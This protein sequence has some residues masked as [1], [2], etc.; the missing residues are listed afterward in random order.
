M[1]LTKPKLFMLKSFLK[2]KTVK[3]MN[4]YTVNFMLETPVSYNIVTDYQRHEYL[5]NK[6]HVRH[7]HS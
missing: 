2:K 1:H 3:G 7:T 5:H 4:I 6:F